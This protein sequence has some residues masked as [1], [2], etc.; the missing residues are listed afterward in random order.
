MTTKENSK[1]EKIFFSSLSGPVPVAR[2]RCLILAANLFVF[3]KAFHGDGSVQDHGFWEPRD[4]SEGPLIPRL[5][6]VELK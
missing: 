1:A 2:P 3:R 6:P 4:A 5:D